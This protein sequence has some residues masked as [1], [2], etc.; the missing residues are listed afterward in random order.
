MRA[1]ILQFSNLDEG[2]NWILLF[3]TIFNRLELMG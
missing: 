3:R 2:F 1:T